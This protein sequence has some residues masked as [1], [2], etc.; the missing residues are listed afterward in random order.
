MNRTNSAHQAASRAVREKYVRVTQRIS[1]LST[2]MCTLI[3]RRCPAL[4]SR[5]SALRQACCP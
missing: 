2:V 5:S 1:P 4:V 3:R